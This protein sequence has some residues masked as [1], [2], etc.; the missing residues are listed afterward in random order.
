MF[1]LQLNDMR[2]PKVEI[3]RPVVRSESREALERFLE[4]QKCESYLSEDRWQKSFIKGGL[5]EW[6]N[7]PFRQDKN[8]VDAG[9]EDGW[10]SVARHKFQ[11]RIMTIPVL[12]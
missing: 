8:I 9:T 11:E 2:L 1:V 12:E 7:Q 10:A 6:Y 3:L 5:L 4:E